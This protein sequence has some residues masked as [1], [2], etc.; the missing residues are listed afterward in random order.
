MRV[1]VTGGPGFIGR[2]VVQRFLDAGWDVT[3]FSLP[4]EAPIASWSGPVRMAH[5]DLGDAAAVAGAARECDLAIHLAAPVGVAG[6]YQWQWDVI[7]E[8]TRNLCQAM[9]AQG[10]R[11]VVASSIAV[12][13]TLIQTQMCREDDGHGP[14]AGAYGRAKQGQEEV[15]LEIAA[16]TGMPLTLVR[17]ANVYG[18]G[19]ASAWGDR[20]IEAIAATGG[21]VF[22]DATRNDAGLVYVENLADALFLA[23]TRHEAIGRTYNVCDENS[24]PWRRFFDDMAAVAGKPPPPVIPLADALA[25]VN[26]NEDPANLVEPKDPNL[27]SMEGLNLVGFDN[28]IDSSRIR[29]ELSWSPQVGYAQAMQDI[30]KQWAER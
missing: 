19:G 13:G 18:L 22:G 2:R 24:V 5:G 12:Y 29:A 30:A 20:L 8:G 10:A 16:T 7:A 15:A 28:R 23:G 27:P 11:V 9:A 25:M 1:L 26:A 14:W 3:S 4:G 17:P 6:R 21:A